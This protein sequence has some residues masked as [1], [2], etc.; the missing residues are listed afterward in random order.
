MLNNTGV[1][2]SSLYPHELSRAALW[3]V[4]A[5]AL[6]SQSSPRPPLHL[7]DSAE[8]ELTTDAQTT[9]F[10]E[11]STD[12]EHWS[13]VGTY[14]IGNG[15]IHA[16]SVPHATATRLFYRYSLHE[17]NTEDPHDTDMDGLSNSW[18]LEHTLNP[19][20][21]DQDNNGTLDGQDDFD[22]DGSTNSTEEESRSDPNDRANTPYSDPDG[23]GLTSMEEALIGTNPNLADSNGNDISDYDEDRDGDGIPNGEDGWALVDQLAPQRLP[24]ANYIVLISKPLEGSATVNSY[25]IN[26]S[27]Q[28]LLRIEQDDTYTSHIL[29]AS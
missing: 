8:L 22:S 21:P 27:L 11:T 6:S 14:L 23:D 19:T 28:A 4:L 16:E 18:E 13:F 10:L 7:N 9:Y 5:L 2:C 3:C 25:E 17:T 1:M 24:L 15:L 20:N 29:T 12:L 26:N